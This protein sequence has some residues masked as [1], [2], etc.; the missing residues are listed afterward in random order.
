VINW[1]EPAPGVDAS[2]NFPNDAPIP[3]I[4]E[5]SVSWGVP[6]EGVVVEIL[7]YLELEAGYHKLGL[8]S[9]GGHKVTAGFSTNAPV[10][11][12]FDDSET[13]RV[14]TYYGRSQFFDIVAPE[15][16]YYPIRY[17]WFQSVQGEEPG[18]MLELFSVENRQLV[19]LND[20][21]NPASIRA[22][23]AGVL[24]DPNF[25]EPLIS[26]TR[27]G[28][29]LR[30]EWTGVLEVS[31]SVSGPYQPYPGAPQSPLE[32]PT[33]AAPAAFLRARAP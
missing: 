25:E 5:H 13:E 9:E 28:A 11:S 6:A 29:N 19:L 14:P 23:R 1:F 18:M 16:G 31:E 4:S 2:L 22:Y 10:L 26:V 27:S 24:T 8:Y 7:T 30:I 3:G 32:I 15:T 12:L 20:S 33:T 17:L 21:N